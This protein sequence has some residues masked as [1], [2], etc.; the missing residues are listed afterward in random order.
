MPLTSWES[1]HAPAHSDST[2]PVYQLI[3]SRIHD[4]ADP[5]PPRG[6]HALSASELK[7]LDDWVNVGAPK[8]TTCAPPDSGTDAPPDSSITPPIGC[9]P[10]IDLKPATPWTQPTGDAD[11][12][13]CYGVE[14]P[15]GSIPAGTV[16]HVL[17]MTPHIVNTK[18]VHHVLLYQADSAVSPTPAPCPAPGPPGGRIVYGWAPGGG[19][20]QTPPDV[21]FPY[22]A[23]THWVVQ[24]HYNNA[25]ALVGE[26]DTSGFSL[27]TTDQPVKYDADVVAF[28][29]QSF[30]IPRKSSKA[31][32]CSY[33]VPSGMNSVHVFS[34]F[35]HLH[36]L[37]AGIESKLY[38]GG[39]GVGI[40]LGTNDPWNFNAQLWFPLTATM[41]AGDVVKTRCAWNNTTDQ[42]VSFGPTTEDEMCYSFT[43]YYPK[44]PNIHWADPAWATGACPSTDPDAGL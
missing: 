23:S 3:E 19:A 44:N 27:C 4:A 14:M 26:Q 16:R 8:A 11:D 30:S 24:V 41:N 38:P 20:M 40:D 1:V 31:I 6:N 32:T 7:T 25:N 28:G 21:G 15:A 10:N 12:Y 37:G 5:M 13:V 2:K 36:K 42:D 39:S 33:T 29:S 18:I 22:D 9:T 17:G 34:A 35:P 43:A